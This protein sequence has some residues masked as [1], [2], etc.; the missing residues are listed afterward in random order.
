MNKFFK[1]LVGLGRDVTQVV[2]PIKREGEEG[3]GPPRVWF[4]VDP[5]EFY[6]N[7]LAE[8]N[9]AVKTG[10][11]PDGAL[12]QYYFAALQVNDDAWKYALKPLS[13]CP[14]H[15]RPYRA[16]VLELA[17]LWWTE[18]LHRVNRGLPMGLRILRSERWKL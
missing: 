18:K 12:Y 10:K 16:A 8:L 14:D 7:A 2:R 15:V 13:E 17:R 11:A 5:D 4:E 9:D 1:K 6:P 3:D